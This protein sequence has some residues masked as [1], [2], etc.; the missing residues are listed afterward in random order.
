MIK[1]RLT[2]GGSFPP[3]VV[4]LEPQRTSQLVLFSRVG[5]SQLIWTP[6]H[7]SAAVQP[8]FAASAVSLSQTAWMSPVVE[9]SPTI[10]GAVQTLSVVEPPSTQLP[11]SQGLPFDWGVVPP[12][13]SQEETPVAISNNAN[14]SHSI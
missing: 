12:Q 6:L 5:L 9:Y 3:P 13:P 2:G 1:R 7:H 4:G 10:V 14:A 11:P 8:V